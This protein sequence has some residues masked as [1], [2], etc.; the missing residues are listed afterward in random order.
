MSEFPKKPLYVTRAVL[1]RVRIAKQESSE[2]QDRLYSMELRLSPG[3]SFL[4]DLPIGAQRLL[5]RVL[6]NNKSMKK[7]YETTAY[8]EK[9]RLP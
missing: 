2:P 3:E 4:Y 8:R 1:E 7:V 9:Y 5:G 6:P